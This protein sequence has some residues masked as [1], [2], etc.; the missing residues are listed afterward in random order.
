MGA[1]SCNHIFHGVEVGSEIRGQP[2]LQSKIL[3]QKI[4][5]NHNEILL[6]KNMTVREKYCTDCFCC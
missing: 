1:N 5:K 6:N 2:G 4:K 3:Y